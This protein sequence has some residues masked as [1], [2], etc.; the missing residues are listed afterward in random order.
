[1]IFGGNPSER[2]LDSCDLRLDFGVRRRLRSFRVL[3]INN[4]SS[5]FLSGT[6]HHGLGAVVKNRSGPSPVFNSGGD[7]KFHENG[8]SF[9]F[10]RTRRWPYQ[11]DIRLEKITQPTEIQSC[12][13]FTRVSS[14]I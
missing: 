13:R 11:Q 4:P 12:E 5:S 2:L 14:D 6:S 1:M 10:S 8:Q 3:S 7:G 9:S